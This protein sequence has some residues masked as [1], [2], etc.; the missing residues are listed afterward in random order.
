MKFIWPFILFILFVIPFVSI[1]VTPYLYFFIWTSL[2]ILVFIAS[3]IERKK[4][5][6]DN[7]KISI[8]IFLIYLF[9]PIIF[10]ANSIRSLDY[11]LQYLVC[12]FVFLYFSQADKKQKKKIIFI[13]M[14]S[15]FFIG[16]Y[17]LYQHFIL[18]KAILNAM[19][20]GKIHIPYAYKGIFQYQLKLR[21]TLATFSTSNLLASYLV[22][23]TLTTLGYL[24]DKKSIRRT[25]F[26]VPALSVSVSA[27]YFTYRMSGMLALCLGFAIFMFFYKFFVQ[28][29][30]KSPKWEMVILGTVVIGL[31]VYLF[32]LRTT[33]LHETYYFQSLWQTLH[34]RSV[35]WQYLIVKLIKD[36]FWL[37]GLGNYEYTAARLKNIM[38]A[39][40]HPYTHNIFLQLWIES[41]II[42]MLCFIYFLWALLRKG[43]QRLKGN[44][45]NIGIISAIFA[46]LLF[47]MANYSFFIGQVSIF[48][49]ILC[50]LLIADA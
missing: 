17:A 50:G 16:L 24:F 36:P 18:F 40:V 9:I 4:F 7:I 2:F 49:W 48:W 32:L 34:K 35:T 14:L 15:S 1:P 38:G 28:L 22:M 11:F 21:R 31:T 3:D 29:K 39:M 47:D 44:A 8:L 45:L 10:S 26:A 5:K 43:M 13:I 42:G 12:I 37:L 30:R 23:T 46:F 19:D 25:V 27:L 6:P 33:S 20:E 41:G